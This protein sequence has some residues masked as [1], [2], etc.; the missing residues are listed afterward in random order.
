MF[1]KRTLS[2][3]SLFALLILTLF[4]NYAYGQT[5]WFYTSFEESDPFAAW[6]PDPVDGYGYE[7]QHDIV[8]D[9]NNA[10]RSLTN[11]GSMSYELSSPK[12]SVYAA[13]RF[14]INGTVPDDFG[15]EAFLYIWDVEITAYIETN[16]SRGE[17]KSPYVRFYDQMDDTFDIDDTEGVALGEWHTLEVYVEGDSSSANHKCWVDGRLIANVTDSTSGFNITKVMIEN[18]WWASPYTGRVIVDTVY[19]DDEYISFGYNLTVNSVPV[20]GMPF[21]ID[22]SSYTTNTSLTLNAGTYTLSTDPWVTINGTTYYFL[23]WDINGQK[24]Y[25]TTIQLQISEDTTIT[26]H[27]TRSFYLRPSEVPEKPTQPFPKGCN[28]LPFLILFVFTVLISIWF[29]Y[30]GIGWVPPILFIVESIVTSIYAH[31]PPYDR[32][33]SIGMLITALIFIIAF[34]YKSR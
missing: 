29:T 10:C 8:Y 22:G 20:S 3:L 4:S 16:A 27:L 2:S 19:I 21:T 13:L 32:Y 11:D 12:T 15:G 24:Y 17:G 31:C 14:Y 18:V 30:K 28:L 1:L 7:I 9:G 25:S 26:A 23:Y 33:T 6:T 34:L 5:Y